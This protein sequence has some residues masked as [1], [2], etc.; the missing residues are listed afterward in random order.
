M[1][2]Q[3]TQRRVATL[4]IVEDLDVVEQLAAGL[5]TSFKAS[6]TGLQFS[7]EGGKEALGHRIVPA[8]ALAAHRAHPS[9]DL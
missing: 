2:A 5:E 1:R 4:T 6:I 9:G 3:V 7:L 8:V